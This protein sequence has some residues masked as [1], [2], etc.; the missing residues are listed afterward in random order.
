MGV[1][2]PEKGFLEFLREITKKHGT[3]LIFDEV[4]TGFRL[5]EGG[6][7]KYFGVTPDMTTLGKIAGGG[8]PLACYGGKLE[9]MQCVAPLGSV[10]Q[11]GTLSGNPC[12]VAAGIET[13]RQIESIPNFYE[14][15]DRKSAMIENAIREKGLNVNRCGSLMT[16]FFNDERVKS[17]DEARACDTE[18][19]GRY[20]RH[21]LQSGIYTAPSQFEAMFVS[22]AHSDEDI[23]KTIDAIKAYR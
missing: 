21:M 1:V 16:V 7:S 13:I 12:A 11:A 2:P 14:E 17:Y 18:S 10:Y 3:V 9:I 22:Y 23:A 15:L 5:S 8:M 19:Y 4:I 6:A 20:Y